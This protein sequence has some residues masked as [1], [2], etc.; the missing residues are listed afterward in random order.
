MSTYPGPRHLLIEKSDKI[1]T[2]T[3][4]NP[5]INEVTDAIDIEL[6]EIFLDINRDPDVNVMVLT[7]SGDRVFCGGGSLDDMLERSRKR[8]WGEWVRGMRR[9]RRILMSMLD[10]D[11]PIIARVQGHAIGLGATLALY[12]D[13]VIAVDSAKFADPHVVV[14]LAAG[15]GGSL[16][17]PHLIGYGRA[18]YYLLTGDRIAAPDAVAMGLIHKAVP[19]AELDAAVYG[20]ADRL[21]HMSRIAICHTKRAVNIPL[22]RD[23]TAQFDAHLGLETWSALSSDHP[24]AVLALKEK[25]PPKFARE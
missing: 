9:A 24:E 14:G 18:K 3:I 1:V 4:N 23:L 19:V 15:D 11:I 6:S 5:P 8:E 21:A 13:I 17:W 25:R 20:L 16:M 7:A 22:L 10:C 2:V 12:S